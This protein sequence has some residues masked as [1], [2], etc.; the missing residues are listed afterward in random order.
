M[1]VMDERI[2][3]GGKKER[4]EKKKKRMKEKKNEVAGK[5]KVRKYEGRTKRMK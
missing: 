5:K 1:D 3:C 2:K 4:K